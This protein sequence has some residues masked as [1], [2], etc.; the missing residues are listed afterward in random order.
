MSSDTFDVLPIIIPFFGVTIF[1]GVITICC[2]WRAVGSRFS[3]L[4][5]RI[6][7]LSILPINPPPPP[8]PPTPLQ[9]PITTYP[10]YPLQSP[11]A[12]PYPLYPSGPYNV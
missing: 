7:Q 10:M 2:L 6:E 3:R 4:E 12:I 9:S 5:H 1:S 8:P 11:A